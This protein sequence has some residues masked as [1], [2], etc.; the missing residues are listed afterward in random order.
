MSG[1]IVSMNLGLYKSFAATE[2][3]YC[4]IAIIIIQ[5]SYSKNKYEF[6]QFLIFKHLLLLCMILSPLGWFIGSIANR[7]L[8]Y[9]LFLSI[10]FLPM[11]LYSNKRICTSYNFLIVFMSFLLAFWLHMAIYR[12]YS[13][14]PY[15][16][17]ILGIR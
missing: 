15:T 5:Y 12:N 11:V 3:T 1:Y 13:H 9:F 10:V 6:E 2:F 14:F 4:L 7:C 8:Y 16:S 17:Q